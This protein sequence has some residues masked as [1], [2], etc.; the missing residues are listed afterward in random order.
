MLLCHGMTYHKPDCPV[1]SAAVPL[2]SCSGGHLGCAAGVL[3]D[4]FR[5]LPTDNVEEALILLER[6]GKAQRAGVNEQ[7]EQLWELVRS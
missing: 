4:G 2:S 5:D 1:M 6:Q 3:G 7:G